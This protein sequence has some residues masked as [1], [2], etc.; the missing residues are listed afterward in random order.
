MKL[1]LPRHVAVSDWHPCYPTGVEVASSRLG[2]DV[3]CDGGEDVCPVGWTM[4]LDRPNYPSVVQ[5]G[6]IFCKSGGQLVVESRGGRDWGLRTWWRV[7]LVESR[8]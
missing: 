3:V 2:A 4:T 8:E 5:S 6:S 1:G 7:A